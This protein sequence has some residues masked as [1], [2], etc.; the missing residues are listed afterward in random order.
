MLFGSLEKIKEKGEKVLRY[1]FEKLQMEF[2]SR[3]MLDMLFFEPRILTFY[4][5]SDDGLSTV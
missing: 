2:F 4:F 5:N 3:R 1:I